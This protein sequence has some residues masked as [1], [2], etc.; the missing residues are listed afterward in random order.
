MYLENYE[1]LPKNSKLRI[2]HIIDHIYPILGYQETF[3]AKA[4]ARNNNLVVISSDR[5]SKSIYIANS[6]LLKKQVVGTGLHCDHGINILRLPVRFYFEFINSLWLV[7][8]EKA[9]LNFKP[10]LII[11]HGIVNITSIRLVL[12]KNAL[13]K[14]VLLFDD[15]MTY[16]AS[17]YGWTKIMYKLFRVFFTPLF[18]KYSKIFVAVT[19]ETKI[20]MNKVYGI[21]SERI[22][23]I[24]LGI[25]LENFFKD[26][27]TRTLIRQKFGIL[28]DEIV[29]IYAGK[30]VREKGVHL[31]I[32]A[33]LKIHKKYAKTRF[34]I[35]GG[36]DKLYL[37][38]LKKIVK[39][40][41]AENSFI[42]LDAVPNEELYKYYN[43]SDIGVWPLQ[44][45]LTMLEASAC[46]LPIIISNMSGATERISFGNGLLYKEFDITDLTNKFE[47]L[48]NANLRQKMSDKAI[49]F[50]K[51][52]S[53]NN[54]AQDFL[55]IAKS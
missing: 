4:H 38:N 7:G 33:A 31:F 26:E 24:P 48:L 40:A 19:P 37:Q 2:L 50:A 15:H 16:N 44:C 12:L 34:F 52:Y 27:K 36:S 8:L 29:F 18:L 45:S 30:I 22:V 35:I 5:Y 20:F 3:L 41:A 32:K 6:K 54:L 51:A 17:R 49:L 11:S 39:D 21:P 28:C 47:M 25:N 9:V 46:G 55:K 23:I 43:A 10:D 14:T 13:P 42:F 1:N 53:W